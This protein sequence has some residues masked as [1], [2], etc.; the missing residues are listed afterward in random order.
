[1]IKLYRYKNPKMYKKEELS[2]SIGCEF[3]FFNRIDGRPGLQK[4]TI[5]GVLFDPDHN[6]VVSTICP[7]NIETYFLYPEEERFS[8]PFLDEIRMTKLYKLLM[9]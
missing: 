3:L 6:I 9:E 5:S 4:W 1:M 2:A 7:D 8:I